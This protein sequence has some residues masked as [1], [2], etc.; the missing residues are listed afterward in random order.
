MSKILSAVLAMALVGLWGASP[1][2]ADVCGSTSG[3]IVQ[4]CGFETGDFTNWTLSGNTA[5]G[6]NFNGVDNVMPNSGSYA[7]Y[8]GATGAPITL[9]QTVSSALANEQYQLTF[10]LAQD[11]GST[12]DVHAFDVLFDGTQLYSNNNVPF[13]DGYLKYTFS[14][15]TAAANN[16][17]LLRFDLQND[18]DFFSLDDV[19]LVDQGPAVPEPASFLL[20]VPA[21]A[22][23][24]MLA[25]RRR[26]A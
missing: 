10:Y 4:N 8:F 14:V 18:D 11:S 3:N 12:A 13:S 25:R 16:S 26:T 6:V 17:N 5:G 21:L 19:S 7:A 1:A 15:T 2:R 9:T 24:F 23:L 22:G 20:V